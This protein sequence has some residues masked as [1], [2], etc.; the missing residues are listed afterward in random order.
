M[1]NLTASEKGCNSPVNPTLFGPIRYCIYPKILRSSKVMKATEISAKII[2]S[3]TLV[4][5]VKII[6]S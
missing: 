6:E 5:A 3:I 4:K 2:R 1:Y